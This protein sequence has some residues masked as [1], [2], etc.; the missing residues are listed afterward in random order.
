[1]SKLM[2]FILILTVIIGCGRGQQGRESVQIKGSD[3]MINLVQAWAERFMKHNPA[4][5]VAV[6]GGGSGTGIAALLNK[7]CNIASSSRKM[8]TKELELAK[9]KGIQPKEFIVGLDGI[10]V[11]VHPSN[12]I[13]KLTIAQASDIFTGKITNWKDIG[14]QEGKIVI[15]SRE[16][17]SGTYVYFKE[18]VL[19]DGEYTEEALLLP[20]SQAIADE[21]AQNQNAIGYYGMGYISPKQKVM[22]I[23][24]NESSPFVTPTIEN[25]KNGNYYIARPLLLYTN[26]EPTGVVK[27]F[28]DFIMS[29]EGQKVVKELDFVPIN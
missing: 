29:E 23:A 18:H 27:R 11:V 19:G 24:K 26:G 5:F 10:A 14:G 7:T 13:E 1:M 15:L 3:T 25:V 12:P 28:L 21:V 22:A 16:V 6:T 9:T 17:N 20:S 8:E 4:S 2:S